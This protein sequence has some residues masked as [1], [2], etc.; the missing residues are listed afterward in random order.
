MILKVATSEA[1]VLPELLGAD[2]AY[3]YKCFSW[4]LKGKEEHRRTSAEDGDDI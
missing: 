1:S 4:C 3:A 2:R